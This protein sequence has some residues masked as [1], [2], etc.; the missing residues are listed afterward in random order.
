VTERFPQIQGHC[1]ACGWT[2]LF[3]GEGGYITCSRSDCP[4]P[5][6]ATTLLEHD[7]RNGHH[8]LSTGCLH[9]KHGYCQ[10]KTGQAGAKTPAKCK[11]CD[12]RCV[13]PCHKEQPAP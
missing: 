1:P 4:D 8:Y 13:C 2:T 7:P 3:L 11:F 9:D 5:D 10:G 12:A 6:A